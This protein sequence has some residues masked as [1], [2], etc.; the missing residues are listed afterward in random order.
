MDNPKRSAGSRMS[1]FAMALACLLVIAVLGFIVYVITF[2]GEDNGVSASIAP[3]YVVE[4]MEIYSSQTLPAPEEY[5]NASAKGMVISAQYLVFPERRTGE[6]NVAILMRLEDGTTRTENA[7]LSVVESAVTWELGTEATPQTLLGDS[8][9][10]ATFVQP[11]SEFTEVGTYQIKIDKNGTQLPFTLT[12]QDTTPP[13]ITVKEPASFSLNQ[14]IKV[15][16]V[17]AVVDCED[18]NDVTFLLSGLPDTSQNCE[19]T[20]QLVATDAA[21]NSTTCDVNYGVYGDCTPPVISGMKTMRT[22]RY[23]NIDTMHDITAVDETDGPVPV[24]VKMPSNFNIKKEGDYTVTY[25]AKDSAGNVAEETAVLRVISND[26]ILDTLTEEDVLRM[27]Y[28]INNTLLAPVNGKELTE[29]EKAR[30]IYFQVQNHIKF[31]DNSDEYPWHIN[32]ALVLQRGYGDCRNYCGYAKMLYTCAGFENMVVEHTPESPTAA[33]HFW[34]L[35]KIDGEW[36]HCD[37]TPRIIEQIF[38]MWTD[39]QMDAYSKKD[40]NCF[41]RDRSLYPKT[42]A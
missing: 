10:G 41:E 3:D 2:G 39:A 24:E 42:P 5:L 27:G 25:T 22:I 30:K 35:V 17:L 32:A 19:G 4:R 38:F 12:V 18:K 26:D 33:K 23:V 37:S 8:F 29:K 1:S 20:L 21:G 36:W 28:Y 9:A 16:D 13:K 7:V 6:Q 11:L 31:K 14:I 34:N 15:E 40:G